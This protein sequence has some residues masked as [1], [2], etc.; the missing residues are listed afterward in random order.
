MTLPQSP[1]FDISKTT[2]A[3]VAV[4]LL[5]R[6]LVGPL[7]PNDLQTWIF[8]PA[9]VRLLAVTQFGW[10]GAVGLFLGAAITPTY[11]GTAPP[12]DVLVLAALMAAGAWLAAALSACLLKVPSGDVRTLDGLQCYVFVA[13]STAFAIGLPQLYHGYQGQPLLATPLLLPLLVSELAGA[14]LVLAGRL[15]VLT[16]RREWA[17]FKDQSDPSAA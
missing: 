4:V 8:L 12:E 13:L 9:A 3:W 11:L 14:S 6:W 10:R 7:D 17:A 2:L 5:Q 15:L 1:V 16:A